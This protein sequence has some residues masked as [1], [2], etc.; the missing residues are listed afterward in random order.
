[1]TD[2]NPLAPIEALRPYVL[3]NDCGM[4]VEWIDPFELSAALAEARQAVD[5]L[6]AERDEYERRWEED[7]RPALA[8]RDA[9]REA[10][11]RVEALARGSQPTHE[12]AVTEGYMRCQGDVLDVIQPATD[13][14]AGQ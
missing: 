12:A 13:E 8:E 2:A 14:E 10:L 3:I 5:A 11:A 7:A 1:M 4:N 9:A 6:V